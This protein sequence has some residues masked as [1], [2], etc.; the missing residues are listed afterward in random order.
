MAC[1]KDDNGI[2]NTGEVILSSDRILTDTYRSVGFSFNQGKNVPFPAIGGVVPDIVVIN[3]T[4]LEGYITGASFTCPN[5]LF[6]FHLEGS[7]S[8]LPE[9]LTAFNEYN[10]VTAEDFTALA[11]PVILYQVWTVQTAA[12]K[13]AKLVI[14]GIQ[15]K[16][17][18]PVSDYVEV[19]VEYQYQPDGT[20]I[21]SE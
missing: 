13:F 14:K 18:N 9:A 2:M 20:K 3:E 16:T 4:D 8:S 12:Q 10:E 5:N 21:F 15:I 1:E 11:N 19:N 6:A 7:Y 17:D